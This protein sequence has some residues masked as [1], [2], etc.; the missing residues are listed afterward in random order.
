MIAISGIV[1]TEAMYEAGK[2]AVSDAYDASVRKAMYGLGGCK[3]IDMCDFKVNT[4]LIEKYLDDEIDSV[5][6]MYI[7]MG[8]AKKCPS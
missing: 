6:L 4:D 3:K 2:Q 1:I 8:R 7:A 5:Q